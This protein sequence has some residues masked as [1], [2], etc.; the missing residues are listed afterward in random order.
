MKSKIK[1]NNTGVADT[2]Y[3]KPLSNIILESVLTRAAKNLSQKDLAEK[4]NTKQSVISRFENMGRLPSYDFFARLSLSIGY[5]PGMTLRG[6]YMATVPIEKEKMVNEIA[7]RKNIPPKKLVQSIL[8][9]GIE[10]ME[11]K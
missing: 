9:K 8:N 2:N 10:D 4:M 3:W 11:L 6:N 7:K 1:K 5:E